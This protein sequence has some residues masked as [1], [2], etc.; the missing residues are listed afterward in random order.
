MQVTETHSEALKREFKVVV[1]A[2]SLNEKTESR[3]EEVGSQVRIPGFRP[4]K[5][6]MSLLKK[7]FGGHVMGEVLEQA[8]QDAVQTVI[9]DNELR[10]A[11]QPK[12]EISEYE[13]EGD[14]SLTIAVELLPEMETPD[15]SALSIEREVAEVSEEEVDTALERLANSRRGSEPVEEARPAQSGDIVVIDFVGKK[16]GEPFPGGTAEDYSLE[17]G[18]NT[19][20]PG[21]EDALIGITVGEQKEVALTFPEDYGAEDL[22]G[23]AVT[24][25]VTVKE[26]RQPSAMPLDDEMAK[27]FGRETLDELKQAIRDQ[28]AQEYQR[29]S[30]EKTKRRL[31][32]QLAEQFQ[33]EVPQGLVDV[34]FDGIWKQLEQAREN[35]QLDDEDKAKSD[36]D[37]RAEYRAIAERRVRLGLLLAKVGED[38]NVTVTQDD[39]NQA[40]AEQV[41]SFPGQEQA[42]LNYYR[43]N[44][45]AMEEL[46]PPIFENKVVDYILELAQVTERTVSAEELMA[47]DPDDKE[48]GETAA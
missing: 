41:R 40:L 42:V 16:D 7:R 8:A 22:A 17:L 47:P 44:P 27:T 13:P 10:P 12:V 30:R 11:L 32:D 14:L 3:L 4:G 48:G 43:Q 26:L 45:D 19:F 37:L 1:P 18:S 21:F 5:V 23:Q 29:A 15:F 33:Q 2:D 20:I 28:I 34:E 36:D 25:D 31:L 46:R 9:K 24:F 6:P 38:N 39:M 35:D